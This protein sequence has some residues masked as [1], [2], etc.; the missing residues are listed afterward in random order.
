MS[1]PID[2]ALETSVSSV[3]LDSFPLP[4]SHRPSRGLAKTTLPNAPNRDGAISPTRQTPY[5]SARGCFG[6]VAA[7]V[8]RASKHSSVDSTLVEAISRAVAQQLRLLTA[9]KYA[10]RDLRRSSRSSFSPSF[11][12]ASPPEK[13]RRRDSLDRFTADLRKYA[14]NAEAGG[15][16]EQSSPDAPRS[17]DSL[18]TVSALMPFR[19]EFRA[20]GLAVTSNDQAQRNPGYLSRACASLRPRQLLFKAPRG[21]DS[22]PSQ[23]DGP[24]EVL[25]SS[26]N[27]EISFAPSQAEDWRCALIEEVPVRKKKRDHKTKKPRK[28][29]FPCFRAKEKTADDGSWAH[30]RTPPEKPIAKDDVACGSRPSRPRPPPPIQTT[31]SRRP[32]RFDSV[33]RSPKHLSTR[34]PTIKTKEVNALS[35]PMVVRPRVHVDHAV[36]LPTTQGN[37]DARGRK[38][39]SRPVALPS[40]SKS[41]QGGLARGRQRKEAM[42]VPP[43]A[44]DRVPYGLVSRKK[45]GGVVKESRVPVSSALPSTWSRQ[46][47]PVPNLEEELEKTARLATGIAP[48]ASNR[49]PTTST[50]RQKRPML[51]YDPNH[52]GICCR[53]SRGHPSRATAPPNIPMRTSSVRDS[54]S[55]DAA[56]DEDDSEIKDRDVLRGLHVAASA[57]C[58]QEVD[59]FVR[60]QTGLRIRRF[61]ADLMTLE[62]FGQAL[63]GEG[64]EQ[65][66]W[67]RRAEMRALKR[68]VRRSRE[69]T[70]VAVGFN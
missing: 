28:S 23:V 24:G 8:T 6:D 27:T 5:T 12:H 16:Q 69:L 30:F 20:A 41:D 47:G 67:R 7:D 64:R 18:H 68:R 66:A 54:I 51:R 9:A 55:S 44:E 52:M 45:S 14:Q 3:D 32:L 38:Q 61:L 46:D 29:F 39:E 15:K 70:G 43:R 13:S 11:A 36:S 59:A 31:E 10:D 17:G 22:R 49:R 35:K 25:S 57:A 58:D 37:V 53:S 56:E 34:R 65:R 62:A 50:R 26:A 21:R 60:D 63:P 42:T 4:P 33:P 48:S 19:P 1:S 40:R 2:Q